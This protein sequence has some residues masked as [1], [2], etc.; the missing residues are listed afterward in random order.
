MLSI[1]DSN[2]FLEK[3][4]ETQLICEGKAVNK[5]S[6]ISGLSGIGERRDLKTN[7]ALIFL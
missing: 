4:G 2:I 7:N 3:E 1:F 5:L 6:Q